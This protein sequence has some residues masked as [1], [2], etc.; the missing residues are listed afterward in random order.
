VEPAKDALL[1]KHDEGSTE[2]PE[3]AHD[4]EAENGAEKIRDHPWLGLSEDG[5]VQEEKDE[6]HDD[7]E[8]KNILLRSARRTR[9]AV[10]VIR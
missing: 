9:M 2:S 5:C 3:A 7:A 6:R 4:I 8:K 1:A 10:S